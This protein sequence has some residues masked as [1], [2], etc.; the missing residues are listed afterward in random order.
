MILI[1]KSKDLQR[2]SEVKYL[3]TLRTNESDFIVSSLIKL[4]P[5]KIKKR[6]NNQITLMQ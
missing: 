2:E 1:N 5:K 6:K 3:L 4:L